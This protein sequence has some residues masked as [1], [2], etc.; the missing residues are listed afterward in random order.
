VKQAYMDEAEALAMEGMRQIRAFF[1]YDGKDGTY[2]QRARLGA[3]TIGAYSR[4]YATQTNR[5]ALLA[6]AKR[7]GVIGKSKQ[8]KELSE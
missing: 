8:V 2:F 6:A 3:V 1:E 7:E 4:L 5:M